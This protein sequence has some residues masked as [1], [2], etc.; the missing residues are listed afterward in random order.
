MSLLAQHHSFISPQEANAAQQARTAFARFAAQDRMP[1]VR[2]LDDEHE[3]EIELPKSAVPL[4]LDILN[5][6]ATGQ[7]VKILPENAEISTAEAA[8]VLNVSRPFVIKL[9]EAG[10]IP[11]RK[12]GTHRRIRID[13]LLAYKE[14]DT[15]KREAILDELVR[16]AEEHDMGYRIP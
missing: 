9:L 6:L 14:E 7:R 13:D 11:Y 2:I 1:V 8:D 15:R 5:I 10:E 12:V 3:Q 16:I 4:L